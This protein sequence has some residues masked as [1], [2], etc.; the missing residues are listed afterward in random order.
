MPNISRRTFISDSTK[1]AAGIAAGCF[2]NRYGLAGGG[3]KGSHIR[4]GF[5]TYLWGKDWDLPTLIRNAQKTEVYGVELRT[6]HA[7]GV[8]IDLDQ[9]Q[10]HEVKLRFQ[11]SPVELVGLGTNW[12]FHYTDQERLK[13]E[14]EY[15]KASLK[16]SYDVGGT[17]IKVKPNALPE[18]VPPEKTIEQIGK[19]LNEIGAYASDYDQKVRV[20]VHGKDTQQLPNMKKIFDHVDQPNVTICWNC[21]SQ[22]L[23][24]RGLEYNFNLVKN[25]LGDTVH[26]RELDSGEYPYQQLFD[27]FVKM[28]Y[29]GWFLLEAR[30]NPPDR[31]KALAAQRELFT[32]MIILS[33]KK[34]K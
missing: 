20:E 33:Q 7:H 26:L 34:Y 17:G 19:A 13:K 4:F 29:H 5:V 21:N 27:L 10:R 28:D 31:I 18:E 22:D 25:R 3:S 9:R 8:E 32:K 2:T 23:D 16:L 30:E 12:A 15:S 14:I 24:G 11:N 6:E 1:A